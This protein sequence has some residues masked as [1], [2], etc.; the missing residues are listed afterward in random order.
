MLEDLENR[1]EILRNA[2]LLKGSSL[3]AGEK[4]KEATEF[5]EQALEEGA[6]YPT[7]YLMLFSLYTRN[8]DIKR[9][10]KIL[11]NGVKA[12]PESV[13]IYAALFNVY[14]RYGPAKNAEA[15]IKKMIALEPDSVTHKIS[16]A[17][18]YW[19]SFFQQ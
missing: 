16:L 9:A 14:A 1:E 15:T 7:L 6:T 10:V 8:N 19:N 11:E 5:L 18:L 17:N 2:L 12:N 3:I 13:A 4:I